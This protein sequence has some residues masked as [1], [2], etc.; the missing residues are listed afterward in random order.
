MG[1]HPSDPYGGF[2]RIYCQHTSCCPEEDKICLVA[3]Y[4]A[5]H[6]IHSQIPIPDTLVSFQE[7]PE[8]YKYLQFPHLSND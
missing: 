7:S 2:L 4:P 8:R 6:H 3:V 5:A 1:D